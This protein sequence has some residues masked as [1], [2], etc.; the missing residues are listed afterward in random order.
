MLK[1][2]WFHISIAITAFGLDQWTKIWAEK[3]FTGA[4]GLPNYQ[5]YSVIGD[6]WR[7]ALAYNFGSAFSM[8]P[9]QLVPWL[10]TTYFYTIISIIATLGL[11]YLYN[12]TPI[13]DWMTK[14][15]AFLILGGA[16]GNLADR[17]RIGKVVDFIDW[18]FP[19]IFGLTR[20]PTFNL[21]DS[22][23]L[24]GVALIG[25]SPYILK[26]PQHSTQPKETEAQ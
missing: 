13:S 17:F 25:L 20:W 26:V 18:D 24:I 11:L 16:W 6:Y 22:W 21:A 19:D 4:D 5:M 23:V 3:A 10:S 12:K 9:S 2:L 1:K 7:F 14:L 8:K 15:G